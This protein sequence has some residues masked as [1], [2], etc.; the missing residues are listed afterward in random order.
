MEARATKVLSYMPM[1]LRDVVELLKTDL[2]SNN[3]KFDDRNWQITSIEKAVTMLARISDMLFGTHNNREGG[4]TPWAAVSGH[5]G[6][7]DNS[8]VFSTKTTGL[9]P[10]F[11]EASSSQELL[12]TVVTTWQF[13]SADE[14]T[15]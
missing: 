12:S 11:E 9:S 6:T 4:R 13:G 14:N 2:A 5:E 3:I 1:I 8:F 10:M 7:D 15:W